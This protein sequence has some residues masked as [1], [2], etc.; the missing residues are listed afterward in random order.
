MRPIP[1]PEK[2]HRKLNGYNNFIMQNTI[3]KL[4]ECI[5]ARKLA[6]NLHDREIFPANRGEVGRR[7][8]WQNVA[9][10]CGWC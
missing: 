9:V 8:S 4:L 7:G 2:D 1:K 10:D 3:G 5:V 6:R